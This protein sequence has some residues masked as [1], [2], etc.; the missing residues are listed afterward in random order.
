MS[1]DGMSSVSALEPLSA[2]QRPGAIVV[3]VFALL[4]SLAL[5]F[6]ALRT[7]RLAAV[8]FIQ[9]DDSTSRPPEILFFRTQLGYYTGCL[10]LSN[11]FV[12]F[13]GLI[14][15]S[16]VSRS[17][18]SQGSVCSAQA[19]LMQI[20]IW[21]TCWFTSVLGIHTLTS[22]VFHIH[23]SRWR[24]L[25]AVT[26]GWVIAFIA[27]LAPLQKSEVYS[28]IGPSCGITLS[29]A[30]YTYVLEA[31]PI[32]LAALVSIG[33]YSV[34]FLSLRG[35]LS[36]NGLQISRGPD[37]NQ[38]EDR[39]EDYHGF[40]G[41]IIW[42]MFWFPL[43]FVL[44]S[45]PF[46]ITHILVYAG[47]SVSFAFS[48]FADACVSMLGFVNVC[49]LYNTFRVVSPMYRSPRSDKDF[50]DTVMTFGND[51][52]GES[53]VVPRNLRYTI[54]SHENDLQL[55][56]PP[57]PSSNHS[58]SSSW[59]SVDSN[60]ELLGSED[61]SYKPVQ[62]AV[63]PVALSNNTPPTWL[64]RR[65][66]GEAPLPA[67]SLD[68][69]YRVSFLTRDTEPEH[70]TQN[71][72]CSVSF[73]PVTDSDAS[74]KGAKELTFRSKA[75]PALDLSNLPHPPSLREVT[76]KSPA[77]AARLGIPSACATSQTPAVLTVRQLDQGNSN[78]SAL[79]A[80]PI[81][82]IEVDI[83]S[84]DHADTTYPPSSPSSYTGTDCG[85]EFSAEMIHFRRVR[86]LPEVPELNDTEYDITDLCLPSP[87]RLHARSQR[88]TLT[89]VWSQ[90]TGYTL[91][92]PADAEG[93]EAC[94]QLA[95]N[96]LV[97]GV[98]L[99]DRADVGGTTRRRSTPS[100]PRPPPR[101]PRVASSP[102]SFDNR[103]PTLSHLITLLP[104]TLLFYDRISKQVHEISRRWRR[105][106]HVQFIYLRRMIF[107]LDPLPVLRMEGANP[108]NRAPITLLKLHTQQDVNEIATGCDADIG[109]TSTLNFALDT[110][111]ERNAGSGNPAT[112]SFLGGDAARGASRVSRAYSGWVRRIQDQDPTRP[113]LFG[114]LCDDVS[115][116]QYLA[117]RLRLGG[118]PRT[119]NA[120]YVNLQTDG[121]VTTDLWQ[122]PLYFKRNDGDWE[123][124]FI[125]FNNF[126]L[127]NTG[128]LVQ[129]QMSM[130]R[131]RIRTVGISMLGGNS[132]VSGSYD[133]GIHSIRA[134]N[135]E[136]LSRPPCELPPLD[137]HSADNQSGD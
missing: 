40:I 55:C 33:V 61:A 123:D 10:I 87:S 70:S 98:M 69:G 93:Q 106:K 102:E 29:Y 75:P 118:D 135:E 23:P 4:S 86:P 114:E 24:S 68:P 65:V 9:R 100:G 53:P 113:S 115:Y 124:I 116:H 39:F 37:S 134:V 132:G 11:M 48:V 25:A 32:I 59:T 60:S 94:K 133:L 101:T 50:A 41:T 56:N 42:T 64:S 6:I 13:A 121:P 90:D 43:A 74:R 131:Q 88:T 63:V 18:L 71:Q 96:A 12:S 15:F 72:R 104:K 45:L 112:C 107:K 83:W 117:L 92:Q 82:R 80:M 20:G 91:S 78:V 95:V 111:P 34:I 8:V 17:G 46:C 99:G 51:A 120:Y 58:R 137:Q 128:E 21:A 73:Q 1:L 49:L 66:G 79:R 5:A 81:P 84:P 108:P 129:H 14:G 7:I 105:Q 103:H 57:Q 67:T 119:R 127:T 136:D 85:S 38:R 54:P 30:K 27:G 122:H 76:N 28:P 26:I 31:L 130:F 110:S 36:L 126:I 52:S 125:P 77:L 89:S 109:G 19:V 62:L 3:A 44:L 97:P 16:W 35:K 2:S 47:S 22:L